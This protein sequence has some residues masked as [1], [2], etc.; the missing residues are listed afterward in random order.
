MILL[1][2]GEGGKQHKLK[3]SCKMY[4]MNGPPTKYDLGTVT[5]K[6]VPGRQLEGKRKGKR[7]LRVAHFQILRV[8]EEKR[9]GKQKLF[10]TH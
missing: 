4:V 2:S 3:E 5:K 8:P 7:T 1:H 10:V 9:K 6:L